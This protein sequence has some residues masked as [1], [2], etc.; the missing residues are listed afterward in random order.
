[1]QPVDSP[2]HPLAHE[3]LLGSTQF[4][5]FLH[6]TEHTAIINLIINKI[7]EYLNNY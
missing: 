4:P 7:Q 2:V 6:D 3:H 1:M 5:P